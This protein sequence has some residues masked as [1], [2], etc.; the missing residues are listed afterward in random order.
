MKALTA[1]KLADLAKVSKYVTREW[2]NRNA[3][4]IT[5][6]QYG[7]GYAHVYSN[8]LKRRIPE[9]REFARAR[10]RVVTT[11]APAAPVTTVAT[12]DTILA[13]LNHL[14]K[15]VGTLAARVTS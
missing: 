15:V 12:D 8:S 13:R 5:T 11:S 2:L 4:P 10:S 9:L 1:T 3:E 7:R 14:E 6:I